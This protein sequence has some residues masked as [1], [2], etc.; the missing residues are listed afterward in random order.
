MLSIASPTSFEWNGQPAAGRVAA[1][2][3]TMESASA[4]PE[5]DAKLADLERKRLT[6]EAKQRAEDETA[7]ATKMQAIT[8]GRTDRGQVKAKKG[9]IAA[10]EAEAERKRLEWLAAETQA[11]ALSQKSSGRI[12]APSSERRHPF[13][14][15]LRPVK[16]YSPPTHLPARSPAGHLLPARLPPPLPQAKANGPR[17]GQLPLNAFSSQVLSATPST[18]RQPV[19]PPIIIPTAIKPLALAPAP[20][21]VVAALNRP[22]PTEASHEAFEHSTGADG[23][24]V[25]RSTFADGAGATGMTPNE[26][27]LEQY[28]APTGN[29]LPPAAPRQRHKE[30]RK[31]RSA[32][33]SEPLGFVTVEVRKPS[34]PATTT[35]SP[36]WYEPGVELEPL[37]Q[38]PAAYMLA[39]LRATPKQGSPRIIETYHDVEISRGMKE[40]LV[41]VEYQTVT[42]PQGG[43]SS[44]STSGRSTPTGRRSE[45]TW[46]I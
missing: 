18:K 38:R 41:D 21:V 11:V 14:E 9:Q 45:S 26:P 29:H 42:Q 5:R 3:G 16:P 37:R 35:A 43:A 34:R 44:A 12:K 19:V 2:K 28:A 20:A 25:E 36:G 33:V 8:R 1:C 22:T 23:E 17:G 6:A 40:H 7:A 30:V 15:P 31:P 27:E 46:L 13:I 4:S 24:E 32:S 39:T 10:E